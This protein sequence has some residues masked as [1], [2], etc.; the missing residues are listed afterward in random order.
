MS[1][2]QRAVAHFDWLKP[3]PAG[4]RLPTRRS[5]QCEKEQQPTRPPM[6]GEQMDLLDIAIFLYHQLQDAILNVCDI[7]YPL[8]SPSES[9]TDSWEE[10]NGVIQSYGHDLQR[11][12]VF[13]GLC[14]KAELV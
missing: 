8:T 10:G 11:P 13:P 4:V 14:T 5:Q 2:G 9:E 6:P 12:N 1:N 3:C 7:P